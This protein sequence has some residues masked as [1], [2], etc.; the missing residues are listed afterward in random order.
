MTDADHCVH[1]ECVETHHAEMWAVFFDNEGGGGPTRIFQHKADADAFVRRQTADCCVLP[2]RVTATV[3][4]CFD[5]ANATGHDHI[6][7]HQVDE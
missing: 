5:E 7:D 3:R 2:A 4:N 6:P 1:D